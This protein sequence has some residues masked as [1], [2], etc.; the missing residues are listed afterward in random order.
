MKCELCSKTENLSQL[1]SYFYCPDD[2]EI[3]RNKIHP[4]KPKQKLPTSI[5][6]DKE[7]LLGLKAEGMISLRFYIYMALR[8]EGVTASM[9]WLEV[10]DF[11]KRWA[12][13]S[14]DFITSIASLSKKG[15]VKMDIPRFMAQATT[16]KERIKAMEDAYE[17]AGSD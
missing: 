14:E 17:P 13:R 3:M 11:C 6:I 16:R 15:V 10:E 12:V 9:K 8:L 2:Y 7:E 5:L 4:T 1:G